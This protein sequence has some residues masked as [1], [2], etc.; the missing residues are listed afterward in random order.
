MK[1]VMLRW[2]CPKPAPSQLQ[3]DGPAAT[4]VCSASLSGSSICWPVLRPHSWLLAYKRQQLTLLR[5]RVSDQR[6]LAFVYA[7]EP[8]ELCRVTATELQGSS[9]S[10]QLLDACTSQCQW[11]AQCLLGPPAS[12]C[13][14][15]QSHAADAGTG[16]QA[17]AGWNSACSAAA[18][19]RA[20][21]VL[22]PCC[23]DTACW[24]GRPFAACFA[25]Q[26]LRCLRIPDEALNTGVTSTELVLCMPHNPPMLPQSA[27]RVLLREG[28][29]CS[30]TTKCL[31]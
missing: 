29:I 13:P 9:S 20:R 23:R 8:A 24:V 28:F 11:H 16:S 21:T 15:L 1:L 26:T 4:G 22:Q 6:L 27:F 31:K 14:L 18:R 10:R 7:S 3:S 30:V 5:C 12:R 25:R 17:C 19:N 2:D